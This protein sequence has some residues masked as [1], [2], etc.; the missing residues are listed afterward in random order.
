[1]GRT[2]LFWSAW[3]SGFSDLLLCVPGIPGQASCTYVGPA[4]YLYWI[5]SYSP[6]S[7]ALWWWIWFCSIVC[8]F[9]LFDPPYGAAHGATFGGLAA[10]SWAW[11]WCAGGRAVGSGSG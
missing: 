6:T 2:L 7:L 10:L 1:M 4:G 3:L 11:L 8:N 5:I 9:V